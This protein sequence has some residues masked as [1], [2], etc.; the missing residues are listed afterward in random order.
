MIYCSWQWDVAIFYC[1]TWD[2]QHSLPYVFRSLQ[3]F[4]G[5]LARSLGEDATLANILQMLGEHYSM[6]MKFDT[7]SKELY[8]LK[9]TS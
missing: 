6:V 5:D 8:S 1:L 7:L 2:N 3:G 4:L 9:L